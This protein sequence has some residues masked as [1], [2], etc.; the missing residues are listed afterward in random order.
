MTHHLYNTQTLEYQKS[1]VLYYICITKY[2]KI[3]QDTELF[4]R[5]LKR[6]VILISKNLW[7]FLN[8]QRMSKACLPNRQS[9]KE[10]DGKDKPKIENVGSRGGVLEDRF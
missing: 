7:K 9:T 4:F 2:H 1:K 8:R 3:I 5:I 6:A 10:K